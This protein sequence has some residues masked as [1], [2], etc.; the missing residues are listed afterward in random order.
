M[1]GGARDGRKICTREWTT[2]GA[3]SPKSAIL[4][5]SGNGG[6]SQE[7]DGGVPEAGS[8]RSCEIVW[9]AVDFRGMTMSFSRSHRD[10]E[11]ERRNLVCHSAKEESGDGVHSVA[12]IPEF[13]NNGNKTGKAEPNSKKKF[14]LIGD[15]QRNTSLRHG[16]IGND[17][18][19]P[20]ASGA[21]MKKMQGTRRKGEERMAWIGEDVSRSDAA[22][23][24]GWGAQWMRRSGRRQEGDCLAFSKGGGSRVRRDLI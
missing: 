14:W 12:E 9:L 21:N 24:G 22:G 11:R 19:L 3:R 5:R 8:S 1:G 23:E 10:N 2:L 17:R 7:A 13:K 6:G 4:T 20:D 18:K 15:Q 16:G